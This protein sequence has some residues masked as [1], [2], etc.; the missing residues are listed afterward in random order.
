MRHQVRDAIV[1]SSLDA[2]LEL[3]PL[4]LNWVLAFELNIYILIC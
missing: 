1:L 3:G 4:Q 2:L